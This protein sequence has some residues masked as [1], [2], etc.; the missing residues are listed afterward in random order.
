MAATPIRVLVVDDHRIVRDGLALIINRQ[1]DIEV[2]AAAGSGEEAVEAFRRHQPDVVLMDL[3][4][5]GMTGVEAIRTIRRIDADA[6]IVVLTMF[7]GDEDIYRALEGGATTYL[8]KDSVSD[9]LIDVVR[10]VHAGGRPM[11][12]H[13]KAR[14][15]DRAGRPTLTQREVRVLQFVLR[16]QRNKEIAAALAISE[17]TVEVHLKNI[18][19]KLKQP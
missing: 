9:D 15:A 4:M 5:P 12:D 2:V 14:L 19:T 1:K 3:Q 11:D 10:E 16:G 7:D 6:R 18:F 8:L 17:E 13:V